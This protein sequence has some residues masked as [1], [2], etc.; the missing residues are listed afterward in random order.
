MANNEENRTPDSEQSCP[1]RGAGSF[2]GS[3]LEKI[4]TKTTTW[5]KIFIIVSIVILIAIGFTFQNAQER[6][7]K[8]AQAVFNNPVTDI[9]ATAAAHSGLGNM[10]GMPGHV[11]QA[12]TK[13]AEIHLQFPRGPLSARQAQAFANAVCGLVAKTYVDKGYMPRHVTVSISSAVPGGRIVNYG[14]S[15]YDGNLDKMH[16]EPEAQ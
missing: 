14:K 15:V 3:T 7:D 5:Q 16:W 1:F 8:A 11:L 6:E 2:A 4:N 13:T 9:I 12:D 10:F